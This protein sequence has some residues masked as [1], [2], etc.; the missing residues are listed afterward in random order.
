M[1]SRLLPIHAR[2]GIL[3]FYAFARN[4]DDIADNPALTAEEK[5]ARLERLR[6]GLGSGN[7]HMVPDWAHAYMDDIDADRTS[8]KHGLDLL[9]AFQQDVRQNRYATFDELLDYC[10]RSAVPV[11]RSVLE[12]CREDKADLTAADA[13]CSALQLLNHLRDVGEDYRQLDRI[14]LPQTWLKAEGADEDALGE[15]ASSPALK[16]VYRI[17]LSECAVLLA[18]AAPL[19]QSIRDMRLRLELAVT[20]E[21]ASAIHHR[22]KVSDPL[23]K[24]VRIP[25]WQ[26]PYYL[27]RGVWRSW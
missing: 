6:L 27:L 8:Q 17:Y 16:Q 12:F 18:R 21:L 24:T 1:A 13:L 26:W 5:L 15:D 23:A 14:Y 3:H 7:R 9:S 19:P 10:A 11:G 4:A 2:A 20:L 22:L 25:K